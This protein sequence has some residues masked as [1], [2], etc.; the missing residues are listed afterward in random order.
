MADLRGAP[1]TRAPPG[2][3]NSFNFMQFLGKYGKIVCWRPPGSWRPLLGEI[4]DPPLYRY[5]Q[6]SLLHQISNTNT[7][8]KTRMV[9][10]LISISVHHRLVREM[11]GSASV[12]SSID[13]NGENW[14]IGRKWNQILLSP[15]TIKVKLRI[16]LQH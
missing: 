6:S 10:K 15:S 8:N 3:P 11:F 4:L 9:L 13:H 2:G 5:R 14:M 16:F 12:L 1:W 7:Q